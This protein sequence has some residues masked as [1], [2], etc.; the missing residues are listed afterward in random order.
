MKTIKSFA[1]IN[2]GIFGS[3]K[4]GDSLVDIITKQERDFD[5]YMMKVEKDVRAKT[6]K[7]SKKYS[8]EM[9]KNFE[10]QA[11]RMVTDMMIR[12]L[13]GIKNKIK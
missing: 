12:N 10:S 13:R 8:P 11:L 4:T 6:Q 9:I 2:E 7:D 3:K 5:E 1:E